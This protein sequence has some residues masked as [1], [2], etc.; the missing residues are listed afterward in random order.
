MSEQPPQGR[1]LDLT[2][3]LP[4]T[5]DEVWRMLTDRWPKTSSRPPRCAIARPAVG[6]RVHP[7]S[8]GPRLR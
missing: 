1:T 4:A 6:G 3:D 2:V 5:P 7:R 8:P